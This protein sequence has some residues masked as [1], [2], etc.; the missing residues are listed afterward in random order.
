MSSRS[1]RL[2]CSRSIANGVELGD[3]LPLP[4]RGAA[5]DEFDDIVCWAVSQ[6][7]CTV[8]NTG[9]VDQ[10][11]LTDVPSTDVDAPIGVEYAV[12]PV[13]APF[14]NLYSPTIERARSLVWEWHGQPLWPMAG[15]P[16]VS[17]LRHVP[18]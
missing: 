12:Q 2:L 14:Q 16:Y 4:P 17:A 5:A 7:T 3:E 15:S 10:Q 11:L 6:N 18:R 1:F 13:L 8:S 9:E